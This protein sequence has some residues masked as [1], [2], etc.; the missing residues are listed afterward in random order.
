LNRTNQDKNSL[1]KDIG[2]R[3]KE[4]KDDDCA[5]LLEKR[6]NLDKICEQL[7]LEVQEFAH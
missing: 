2:K 5:D 6:N 4:N 1:N 7:K 3:K